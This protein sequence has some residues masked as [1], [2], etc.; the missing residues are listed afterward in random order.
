MYTEQKGMEK[1]SNENISFLTTVK[2][3]NFPDSGRFP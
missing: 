1:V 3:G 2:E